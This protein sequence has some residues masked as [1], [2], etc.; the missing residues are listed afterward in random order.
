MLMWLW[1]KM[2]VGCNHKWKIIS[3]GNRT[4]GGC[5]AGNYYDLQC[6]RC[7]NVKTKW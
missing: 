2:I 7:G 4:I 1:R 6:E 5:A 3:R